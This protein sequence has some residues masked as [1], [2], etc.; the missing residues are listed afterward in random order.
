MVKSTFKRPN[1]FRV[2]RSATIRSS[3]P[4]Y[5]VEVL[6]QKLKDFVKATGTTKAFQFGLYSSILMG[7][8]VRG[9]GLLQNE[10][11][12]SLMLQV[13]EFAYLKHQDLKHA[14]VECA[15]YYENL[16]TKSPG[17]SLDRW[18]SCVAERSLCVLNHLRRISFSDVRWRQAVKRLDKESE[19]SL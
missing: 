1:Q 4:E 19:T 11:I 2:G 18:A 7:Q 17:G 13:S 10:G 6:T 9:A 5:D 3:T 14:V 8:A 16:W 12:I 15:L